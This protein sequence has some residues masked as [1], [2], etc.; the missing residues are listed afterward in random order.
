MLK[1]GGKRGMP[2]GQGTKTI[3]A[4]TITFLIIEEEALIKDEMI[5]KGRDDRRRKV[6]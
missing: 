6:A 4:S 2:H 5:E 1:I 3:M